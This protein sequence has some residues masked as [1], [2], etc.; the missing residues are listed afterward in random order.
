MAERYGL[1]AS[2]QLSCG[3][4]VHVSVASDDEAVG[5][6]DRI[7]VWLPVLLALS[8]NSPFWQGADSDYA[9][10]R[11]QV[12]TRWPTN[13]PT[14]L[15]GTGAAYSRHLDLLVGTGVPIDDGMVYF[16]ARL[17]QTYP[18][19]EVRVADVCLD[20]RD[21]VLLAAL[22]R[23]LVETGASEWAAGK[24]PPEA[25]VALLRVAMW[26]AGRFGLTG[27]LLDPS[28]HRPR[29]ADDVVDALVTYVGSALEEAGD[30]SRV[31]EGLRRL[32]SQGTGAA[33]QRAILSEEGRLDRTVVRLAQLT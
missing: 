1:T 3:C 22:A 5:A 11:S 13:G 12:M 2:E 17:S 8:A 20:L 26:Q 21:T 33:R 6:L 31:E 10:Y 24:E 29:P 4:H 9:S 25:T 28:T 15:F 18:T 14:E 27:D 32:R 30:I 7:R 16:D 23:A 19:L